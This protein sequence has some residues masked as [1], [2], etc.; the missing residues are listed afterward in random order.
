MR[1]HIVT[2]SGSPAV[3]RDGEV[4]NK[5]I[6]FIISETQFAIQSGYHLCNNQIARNVYMSMQQ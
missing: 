5:G 1:T 4:L 2:F 6:I 3:A